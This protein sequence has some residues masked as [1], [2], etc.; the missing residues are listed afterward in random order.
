MK[1]F[2]LFLL[3]CLVGCADRYSLDK[4]RGPNPEGI[5]TNNPLSLPP[6]YMLRAPEPT[7]SIPKENKEKFQTPD[8]Q[9]E[10]SSVPEKT[11]E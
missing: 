11:E 10:T 7:K 8:A 6:D 3:F 1:L 5:V 2:C 4:D 9:T